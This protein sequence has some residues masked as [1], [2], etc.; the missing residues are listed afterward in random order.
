MILRFI[1]IINLGKG[2]IR[3]WNVLIGE[4]IKEIKMECEVLSVAF[5]PD[6]KIIISGK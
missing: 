4:C 5:S 3:I 6:N 1:L 2:A